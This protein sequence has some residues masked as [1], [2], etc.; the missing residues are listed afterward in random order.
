M[1]CLFGQ[2]APKNTSERLQGQKQC[3][4]MKCSGLWVCFIFIDPVANFFNVRKKR[5]I[6]K[7]LL[8]NNKISWKEKILKN[9][10]RN[11]STNKLL[12]IDLNTRADIGS[13]DLYILD[14]DYVGDPRLSEYT[15]KL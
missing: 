12:H 3:R 2:K 1:F 4:S 15:T 7:T 11:F 13:H 10:F 9:I 6:C 5:W 8:P 14:S